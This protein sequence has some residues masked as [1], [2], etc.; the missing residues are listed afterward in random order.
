[1]LQQYTKEFKTN[2]RLAWPVM[3]GLLGHTLVQF[4]DNIMVGQL[5]TTELAA[6]S[7]GNSF[8]F[9]AMAIGIGFSTAITP[10]I[11]EADAAN[12]QTAS[13]KVLIEGLRLCTLLGIV[14][15]LMVYIAKP[16]LFK[17]GQEAS[18]VALA[19]PYLNWV[20]FSLIP[21]VIFQAFK[22][23]SDGMS[24]TKYSMYATLLANAVNIVINYFLIFGVWIFPKWGVTGAAVGTLASRVVM[25]VFIFIL[26]YK[27]PKTAAFIRGIFPLSFHK[28]ELRQILKLG[29]P[30]SLQMFFEVGF[31]TFA[32]WVCGFLSKDAQAANQI[33]L[34]LSSMTFMVAMGLSVAA[35]IRVGNQKGLGAFKELKRI[36]LSL[37]L[38]T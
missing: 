8:V 28:K 7:L 16:L 9:I 18:V 30:S 34:N 6:I 27:D 21:L 26:L 23:F 36:A 33:A 11:A 19:F 32:I 10:L 24:L 3:L 20:A 37:F 14:L 5:G 4:I 25:L 31:F 2:L 15:F 1:M 12:Q 35:T 38:I 13:Q 17:M 29:L 22:Q